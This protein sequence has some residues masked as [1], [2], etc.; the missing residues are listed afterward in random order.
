MVSQGWCT[1]GCQEMESCPEFL[2][3]AQ[4]HHL[5]V[6]FLTLYADIHNDPNLKERP[7]KMCF[8]QTSH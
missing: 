6:M 8:A 3:K 1:T 7:E 4:L 5:A 2:S